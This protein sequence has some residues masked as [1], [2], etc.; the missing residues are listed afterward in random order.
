MIAKAFKQPTKPKGFEMPAGNETRAVKQM[1]EEIAKAKAKRSKAV[2]KPVDN[3]PT[4]TTLEV[5]HGEASHTQ[6]GGAS[7]TTSEVVRNTE[8][9]SI[10]KVK[11]K[12]RDKVNN[13]PNVLNN[14]ELI[15]Y[16]KL[17][18]VGMQPEEVERSVEFLLP[19]FAAEGIKP[20]SRVLHE[21]ILQMHKDAR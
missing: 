8:E 19:L 11:S 4:F 3:K 14:L 15:D 21:A 1:K 16:D 7:Y 17:I 18:D 12:V 13:K 10:D 2:N 20:T 5:V 9:H 6:P